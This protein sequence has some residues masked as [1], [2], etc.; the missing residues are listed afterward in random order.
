MPNPVP[1]YVAELRKVENTDQPLKGLRI[2]IPKEYFVAGMQAEVEKA[3]RAAIAH[4]ESLGATTKEV[5]LPH[6]DYSLPVYYILATSEASTNLARYDGIRFGPRI[7]KGD[8]WDTY[9]ATRGEGF[10]AEVKRRIVLGTYALSAGYYDAWYGKAAQV[11]T[12]IK[13]DFENA[14]KEVDVLVAA[15][16]PTTAF[17]IGQNTEDP[18][19]MY[20]TDILTISANLGGVCGLNV[21]CGFDDNE[22]PIGLQILGPAF[23][24]EVALR[25]GHLYE[26]TTEWHKRKPRMQIAL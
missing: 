14:F 24:E 6:T 18:L 8:M 20:L 12:L 7:D 15:T 26:Q 22:L 23:G 11:R 25:V 16:S 4:L 13:Q 17:K 9:R 1:D 19:Q 5:S 3:V 10:G 21:P 2:G